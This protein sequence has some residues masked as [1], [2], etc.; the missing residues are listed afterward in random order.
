MKQIKHSLHFITEL[1][2]SNETARELLSLSEEKQIF[3]LEQMLKDLV[4]PKLKT[5]LKELNENNSFATL[6][7]VA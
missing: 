4:A 7:V 2:D 3:F 5:I 6:K 1:D